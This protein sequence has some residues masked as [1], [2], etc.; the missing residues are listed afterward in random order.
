MNTIKHYDV[1]I[2]GGSYIGLSLALLLSRL[3]LNIAVIEKQKF[4]ADKKENEP[5]RLLA[6]AKYSIDTYKKYGIDNLFTTEAE[7]ITYIRVL[8]EGTSAYLDFDPKELGLSQFGIMIE[9]YTLLERLYEQARNKSN[10]SLFYNLEVEDITSQKDKSYIRFSDGEKFSTS[11]VV[12]CDG[13]NSWVR[14]LFG[15]GV[16]KFDYH[17]SAIVCDIA[18]AK[19]HEGAAIEKFMPEGPF[20]I[21]PKPGGYSS[22]I[23]WTCK[24]KHATAIFELDKEI[25]EEIIK[26]KFGNY[27]GELN[28]TSEIKSFPLQLIT[29]KKYIDNRLALAGDAAHAIHPI[30]GQG[31][32]LGIR[33]VSK[34]VELIQHNLELGL[35]IGSEIMLKEYEDIRKID[36]NMM[37]EATH[38]LNLLFSNNILPIKL[39]RGMGLKAI[40]GMPFIRKM[41]MKYAMGVV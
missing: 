26:T 23:I 41:F 34:L 21:L 32:N 18:H 31:L 8:E 22:V 1:V 28:I 3:D 30:A 9:E 14:R 25:T 17:Q 39:M 13:K 27:L 12:A 5:S 19:N 15:I 6:I 35:D 2:F 24:S 7:P 4:R 11:L 16:Q 29:A 10:I 38:N 37:I 20:A 33:D 40:N 36:N